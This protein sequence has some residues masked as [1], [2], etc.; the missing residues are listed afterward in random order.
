MHPSVVSARTAAIATARRELTMTVTELWLAYI[1]VGGNQP[2]PALQGWLAG[3]T[4]IPD[5]DYDFLVQALNDGFADRGENHPMAYSD[6]PLQSGHHD[7]GTPPG[8]G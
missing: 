2:L 4:E 8:P 1:S 3:A 7:V 5:R 6:Q